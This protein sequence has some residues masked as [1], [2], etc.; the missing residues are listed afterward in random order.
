V[1]RAKERRSAAPRGACERPR[2]ARSEAAP[3]QAAAAERMDGVCGGGRWGDERQAWITHSRAGLTRDYPGW[4]A[5]EEGVI[6]GVGGY[7]G[8]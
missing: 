7:R 6:S 5:G 8:G 2:E 3:C 1:G 4:D